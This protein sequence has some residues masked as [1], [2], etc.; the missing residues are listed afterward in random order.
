MND[1]QQKLTLH[2]G[3]LNLEVKDVL[4][5]N[6]VVL[7]VENAMQDYA[8]LYLKSKLPKNEKRKKII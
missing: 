7:A 2:L 1:K 8:E 4:I 5:N 3:K 6:D